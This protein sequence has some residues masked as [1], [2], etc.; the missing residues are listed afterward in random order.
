MPVLL[1]RPF[2]G[3]SNIES[4]GVD[5][6]TVM[7][8]DPYVY[9]VAAFQ[10]SPS[11]DY[12]SGPEHPPSPIYVLE[13]VLEL[14]YPVFMPVE[15]DIL[16]AKEEPLPTAASPITESP[17]DEGDD[18]DESSDDA[19][20]DDIDVDIEG[21]EEEDEYLA[22]ADSTAVTLPTVDH[23][24]SAEETEPFETDES[25]ATP[26]PYPAYRVTA[27]MSIRPQTPISLP[28]D[29]EI[30]R[31]MA[32]PTP[33]PSPLFPL[34]SPL[35]Q[36]P[37]PPLPLLSPPPTD[38]TY[39]EAPLGYR[40]PDYDGVLKERRFLRR[41][42]RF[43][44]G[45]ALLILV[46]GYCRARKGLYACCYRETNMIYAMIKE[47]R[48]DQSLQRARVNRL[49]RDRRYHA[50][51][52]SLIEGE[53]RASHTACAQLMD[54]SDA[55]RSREEIKELRAADR[56]LQAQFIEPLTAL[57]SY[58]TQLTAALGRILILEAARVPTQ[59]EKMAPKRTI[60][61]NPST[62]TTTT[63]TSVTDAQLEALIEQGVAK[64]LAA[65]L[66]LLYV[67]MFLEESDKL[68]RYVGGLPDMIH[69]RVVASRPKTMQ[70][71]IEMENELMDKR[72]NTLAERQAENKRKFDDT[73]GNN[74]SQQQQQNK[75]QNTD[76]AY[77]VGFGEKKPYGGS[78]PLCPKCNYHHDGLCALKCH[79]CNKIGHFAHDCSSTTHVNTA[80]NQKGNGTGQKPTCY[81]CGGQG[82]FKKD[83]P[84]LKNNN[85]GTQ[86]VNATA[87][88]KVYAVG[89]AR[90]NPD[91]NVVTVFPEDLSGLPPTRQVEFQIDLIPSVTPVARASY[92]LA[93]SKMKELSNQLKELSK[94]GFIRPSSS[95]W[96]L[97]VKK[98]DG[99]FRMCIDYRELNK[100]TVKNRYPLPRIDDL[101]DQL[102]GSSVMSFGLTNALAIFMDLM[103]RVC[104]PYLD[105]FMI[106]FIDDILIYSKN[107]K[108][109]E[110]HLKTILELHKKEEFQGIHVDPAKIES[111]K[112][113]TSP[114]MPK[115]IRQFLGL[116]GYYRRFIEGFSKIANSMTKLTQKG[117]EAQKPENIK[118][119]DIG[120]MLVE[121]LK[122]LEKLRTEKLEPRMD[123]ILCLNDRSWFPCYGDLRIVIMHEFHESKY[124]I[125]PG[126]NKMYQD[127]K[128]L[129]WPSG[130]LVQP[131]IP[132]WKWDNITMDFV[133]KL[134]KSSQRYDT[135]WVIVER[136]TKYE[137][138]V[139]MRETN[140]MDK[141]ARMYLKEVVARHGIHV[142]IICDR[143]LRFAS[144]F[145]KSLQKDL[146]EVLSSHGNAKIIQEEVPT[147]LYKDRTVIK[148]RILSLEDKA[149]LTRGDYNTSCFRVI[150]GVNKSTIYF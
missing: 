66:A 147:S 144:S 27:R 37:S 67:Q 124:Y 150:Y 28:S 99:S 116:A 88:A 128:R 120:G 42:Y 52:A 103:N 110:Q 7:P 95:P 135:I 13:F 43:G 123:G 56:K 130:L 141:H 36:I 100:L 98:K 49:F 17:E 74:Q 31:L 78:K 136:L 117:T 127:M 79:K 54:A 109:H 102:Q 47:K 20:D 126:F 39:E 125:H 91:S 23:A 9:V 149:H 32:I 53:A 87:L 73:F 44:K 4:P 41:T 61:A 80:N 2:R 84:K 131:K 146:G 118:N 55:A 38:P 81:E 112:D 50:R 16:P 138:F 33:P 122:D 106:V 107:K 64:A 3:L 63:T 113:W 114:K 71:A 83:C 129:Y 19:E 104:K 34:S 75:R 1:K 35:P 140:P 70:E 45:Y 46:C 18:E 48:D 86:G 101:F 29:I 69:R 30:A 68:E 11:L 25:T 62:T 115:E 148:C 22:H 14:V 6:P 5:G 94:K 97:F 139:P 132:E 76:K 142:F 51:T 96:G 58:Q 108:E 59:L 24:P 65:Q 77:T 57:K 82:N 121:N 8:E 40:R 15:D 89:R 119:E 12:V 92:R 21:D 10:A 137:I 72:N 133:T 60:R 134:P 105:K 90:T 111:I 85:H 26:P 145:W 93:P 143:D